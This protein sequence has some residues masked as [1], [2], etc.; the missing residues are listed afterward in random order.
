MNKYM[1]YSAML[2]WIVLIVA[3]AQADWP[4]LEHAV[5][6]PENAA[7]CGEKVPR[8]LPHVK[9]RFE[10]EMLLT[11]WDRPQVILWLKRAPRFF[12]FIEASLKKRGLPDDLKYIAI[13]ESALRPHVG[14]TKGAIGFWQMM[15]ETARRYGLRVDE[16]V[17]HRRTLYLATPGALDYLK[18]LHDQFSSWTLAAAAYNMGEEGLTAEILEQKTR[19]YYKL[20]LSLE[21]QRYIFRVIAA[22]LI[23]ENPR[24]YGFNV[25]ADMAYQPERFETI[26]LD[27]YQ[28][29]PIR[30]VAEAAGVYFKRI[31]DLNPHLRGHYLQEGRQRIYLPV[32]TDKGFKKRLDRLVAQYSRERDQ[33]IYVVQSGDSLSAIADKFDV[34]LAALIIWNR[35]DLTQTIHPGDRLVIYPRQLEQIKP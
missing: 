16:H 17:D 35:I 27:L 26:E 24:K 14:S 19:D 20:Y 10:K 31:K 1:T 25:T 22:K 18:E 7:F 30:L 2:V 3:S 4:A 33:H 23:M 15:P 13:A 5:S 34:P 8:D 28:Q 9:E 11:L 32:E 6:I 12:P 29:T 21:T